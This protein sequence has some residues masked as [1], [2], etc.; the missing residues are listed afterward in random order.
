[1]D[2]Q[3]LD[4]DN[5]AITGLTAQDF[6]LRE[7]GRPQPIRNFAR[8]DMPLDV[9]FLFDVSASMRPHVER[10]ASAAHQALGV[11]G[12]SDRVAIMVFDRAM[13]LRLPFRGSRSEVERELE[14][15]LD[16]ESFHGGTDITRAMVAAANYMELHARREARR[17]IVI[18]TDDQTEFERD[19][20][21]VGRA[22]EKADAVMSALIAPDAMANRGYSTGGG[23]GGTWGSGGG[24]GGIVLGRG[25]YGR[26]RPGGTMAGPHTRSAGTSEIARQSGG[27]SLPVDDASALETT[28]ARIRQRYAL[29][30]LQPPDARSAEERTIDVQLADGARRRYPDA[31][32]RFR[33]TYLASTAT[34][35]P[36]KF[37]TSTPVVADVPAT[38]PVVVI[39][40]PAPTPV[41]A[42]K[43]RPAISEPDSP[44]GPNPSVGDAPQPATTGSQ[45]APAAPAAQQD[46]TTSQPKRGWR[47]AQPI[48]QH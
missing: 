47:R 8:E 48:E 20:V 34:T 13:R 22:L 23:R 21:R 39:P 32:L 25:G 5:R 14:N 15:M 31:E 12:P 10:I 19:D 36:V 16:Q 4:R 2:V 26:R 40:S 30:F 7:Q 3:V 18:L 35:D 9:L 27:D 1:V 46:S 33:H 41:P 43:R 29:H 37:G 38:D 11:L 24:L 45:P 28:L 6:V 42:L 44:R 17:A